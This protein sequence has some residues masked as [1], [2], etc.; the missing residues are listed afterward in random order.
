M[1]TLDKIR[2]AIFVSFTLLIIASLLA[3]AAWG[4]KLPIKE[5]NMYVDS[6]NRA[7]WIFMA[8][9]AGLAVFLPTTPM[10]AVGGVLF[11]FWFGLLLTTLAGFV[12]A[13]FTFGLARTLGRTFVENILGRKSSAELLEKY[14]DKI[15]RHGVVSVIVLRIMPIMPFNILNLIMGI[16]KVS[17]KNYAAGTVVGLVPSNILAVYFGSLALTFALREFSFYLAVLL[18]LGLIVLAYFRLMLVWSY[19]KK[20][21]QKN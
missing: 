7:P 11:G 13:I 8:V 21:S 15:A 3:Y 1:R 5:I 19:F 10:M 18:T 2:A 20:N 16:S 14:H 12:S 4:D 17:V 6:S 9:Y